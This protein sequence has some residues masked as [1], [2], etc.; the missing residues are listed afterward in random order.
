MCLIDSCSNKKYK[1]DYCQKHYTEK[2]NNNEFGQYTKRTLWKGASCEIDYCDKLVHAKGFCDEHYTK[3]LRNGDARITKRVAKYNDICKTIFP[4]GSRCTN[5]AYCKYYCKKHYN[6]YRRY[7]DPLVDKTK[8]ATKNNYVHLYRPGHPNATKDGFIL[9]HRLVMSEHLG[10]ALV[11]GENV[12]HK[13]GNR[14][15]NR[16]ENL[17][18]WSEMQPSGQR[19][20]D[21]LAWAR[22]IINLYGTADE[23]AALSK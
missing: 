13:N 10:R 11:A 20:E 7:G 16:L 1:R 2:R 3:L 18:L 22:E 9:E 23:I 5:R 6:A 4:E 21:K 19:I 17:E 15:D 14:K 8:K 12:H